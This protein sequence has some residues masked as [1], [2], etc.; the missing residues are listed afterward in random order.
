MDRFIFGTYLIKKEDVGDAIGL[1]YNAGVRRFDTAVI[2]NNEKE[3]GE[4]LSE[5]SDVKVTTKIRKTA[6]TIK[7]KKM[8]DKSAGRLP[9]LS[10]VLLHK[11]MPAASWDALVEYKD[12]CKDRYEIGVSN[13]G[14]RELEMMK[15]YTDVMPDVNQIEFHPFCEDSMETLKWCRE[16]GVVVQGHTLLA[17]CCFFEVTLI[18]QL[19]EYFKVSPAQIMLRWAFQHGVDMVVSTVEKSHVDEWVFVANDGFVLTDKQMEAMNGLQRWFIYSFYKAPWTPWMWDDRVA[20]DD[21]YIAGL[22][23]MLKEDRLLMEGGEWVSDEAL[24]VPL[25]NRFR[26]SPV[27]SKL[28]SVMFSDVDGDEA[29]KR[30]GV[31]VRRLHDKIY[32][33]K[34]LVDL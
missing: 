30:Y 8:I 26:V 34:R 25:I 24:C 13:Y 1:A 29:L 11:P 33:Q 2:Y 28:A 19:A 23:A 31:L 16:N 5:Y 6:D 27:A 21:E 14:V 10:G 18:V 9:H 4:K 12:R 3:V 22:V 15:T 32:E 17:N 7:T 20:E